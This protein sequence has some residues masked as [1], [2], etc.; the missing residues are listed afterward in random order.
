MKILAQFAVLSALFLCATGCTFSSKAT[1][2]NGLPGD[3]GKAVTHI[4]HSK[5]SVTLFFG[6]SQLLGDASL[7]AVV[8]D[9]TAE[10]KADGATSV[11]IVQSEE[12]FYWLPAASTFFILVPQM[13]TV[14]ADYTH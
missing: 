7:Q 8:A 12:Y 11:R 2:F 1:D 9:M 5:F 13:T 14:A 10:A 4:N 3:G 6:W